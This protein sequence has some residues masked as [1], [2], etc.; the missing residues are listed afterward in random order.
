MT[1]TILNFGAGVNST[2]LAIE[3]V[4][5]NIHIDYVLFAD[6]GSEMPETYEHI[7]RM[8]IWFKNNGL[9]FVIVK[10]KYNK[11]IYDYYFDLKTIPWRKF[12][13]CT[14]KFKVRPITQFIK[15]FK[16]E[17]VIQMIG[18]ANEERHRMRKSETKWI[19]FRYP[20]I[21]WNMDR[22]KCIDILRKEGL[23]CVKSGCFICPFQPKESWINL[24]KNHPKLFKK[25]RQME[26]QNRSYPDNTLTFSYSLKEYENSYRT[27]K[28][29][30]SFFERERDICD[31]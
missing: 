17:G 8:K 31:G 5:R 10:S 27:Q 7:E 29:I 12:R 19:Q 4:K 30:N 23:K 1:K 6:T 14:D 3:C 26:E 20:L 9:E 28:N 2:A 11:S 15:K 18:I 16:D 13:D 21:E 22:K 24:L 25:A